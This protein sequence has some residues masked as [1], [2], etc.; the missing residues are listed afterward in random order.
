MQYY[1]GLDLGEVQDYTA[2]VIIEVG[3]ETK[4]GPMLDVRHLERFKDMLYPQ[5]VMQVQQRLLRAPLWGRTELVV[6]ATG[7]GRGPADM[8]Q[9]L[10]FSFRG[11]VIH[12]GEQER[13]DPPKPEHGR[14]GTYHYVP[15]KTIVSAALIPFQ[16]G[17]VRISKRLRFAETLREELKGFRMK[18]DKRTGHESFSHREGE[19]DDLLLAFAMASWSAHRFGGGMPNEDLAANVTDYKEDSLH[20]DL[21]TVFSRPRWTP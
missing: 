4:D 5:V 2:L 6:D 18:Q 14:R 16:Q 13:M 7:P 8:F 1:S 15:K 19:H 12:G 3:E 11:V 21:S 10:D 9:M 20:E 17:R